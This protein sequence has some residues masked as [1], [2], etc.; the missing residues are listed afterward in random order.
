MEA[1]GCMHMGAKEDESC[2]EHTW[3]AAFHHVMARSRLVRV[4]KFT[5][6][7]FL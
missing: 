6:R 2:N 3:A 7:L 5:K 1:K 4:F